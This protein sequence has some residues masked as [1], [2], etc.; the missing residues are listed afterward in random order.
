LQSAWHAQGFY[1]SVSHN[2]KG[3]YQRYMG[4][5]DGDAAHLWEHPPAENAKRYVITMGGI[6]EVIR[7]AEHFVQEGDLRFAATLLRH[8]VSAD[9][10]YAASKEALA[11]VYTRLGFGAEN[12]T[13]RN[14]YLSAAQDL[15][16]TPSSQTKALGTGMKMGQSVEQWLDLLAIRLN[17][18]K[19][20][21]ERFA[22][23]V[24]VTDEQSNCQ[25]RRTDIQECACTRWV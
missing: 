20:G 11:D 19:A 7:K 25:Q 12:A 10:M 23:D 4:W 24:H 8:A 15:G 6:D 1:G 17:G 2:V 22:I 21:A 16:K 14:Y 18:P 3:I 13:W 9:P 5:F